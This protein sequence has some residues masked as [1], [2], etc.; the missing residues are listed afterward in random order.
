M[1]GAS[2]A[3]LLVNV[4]YSLR[5]FTDY[6]NVDDVTIITIEHELFHNYIDSF[7]PKKT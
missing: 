5:S 6:P 2:S 7:L 1:N 3:P 4:R